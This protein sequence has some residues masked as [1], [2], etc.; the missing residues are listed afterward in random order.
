MIHITFYKFTGARNAINKTLSD[1]VTI[2]CNFNLE[3]NT[4]HPKLKIVADAFDYNYCYIQEINKYYFIDDNIIKRNTYYE[5]NLTEDVLTTYK[6]FILTLTGTVT[7]SKT[8]YYLQGANFPVKSETMLKKY[9][10]TDA[11]NHTGYYV[12]IAV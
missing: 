7:R 11:F 5:M 1:G 4:V 12:L 8:P 2:E 9:D 3:Y 6:D 10:F